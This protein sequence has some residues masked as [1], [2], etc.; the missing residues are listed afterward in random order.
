MKT[1]WIGDCRF[2]LAV[3]FLLTFQTGCRLGVE[4]MAETNHIDEVLEWRHTR[5]ESLTRPDGWLTL[6]GL[7]WLEEGESRIGSA[8]DNEI[9]LPPGAPPLV[10]T[11]NRA[12]QSVRLQSHVSDLRSE[13]VVVDDL[14]LESDAS[15]RPTIVHAGSISFHLI[16]RDGRLGVRVRD[17]EAAARRQFRG[18]DYFEPDPAFRV[19]ARLE[20]YDPPK[21]IPI[22]NVTGMVEPMSSPGLLRFTLSG[23]EYTLDPISEGD[24]LF[25]IFADQTSGQETYPPGRYVYADRPD[26]NGEVVIDF[27]KAYNPPCAFT[28]FATCPLPPRQNR[29]EVAITA[30]EKRYTRPE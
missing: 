5:A 19:T 26:A 16:E 28:D 9:V 14:P 22:L 7:Y 15:G 11:L 24:R 6:I 13:G 10:A 23:S 12:G 17:S 20:P 29:L 27:N 3:V 4:E 2:A 18:L 1:W 8:P 30:G 21:E 25:I